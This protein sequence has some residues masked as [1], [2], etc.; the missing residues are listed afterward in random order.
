MKK[1]LIC[2]ATLILL[3][4]CDNGTKTLSCSQT[5]TS[6]GLSTDI[7]Y[8]IKYKD[9][10]VR[11]ATITYHYT[12]NDVTEENDTTSK[13]DVD[14]V[15]A[16]TDGL[17]ENRDSN[18]EN[19]NINSNDVVD[20]A[21]GDAVDTTINGVTDTILDI[22]GIRNTYE[23]QINTYKD[24]DGF[25]YKVEMDNEDEYKVVYEIDLDKI[26][27]SDL[28]RFNIDRDFSTFRTNYEN[29]GYVC[30]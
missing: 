29:S 12:R 24:I 9:N 15:K 16:D 18:D 30:R 28:T 17:T 27:D 11:Y 19:N 2:L 4:G 8:D 7:K 14:G 23:N 20:G 13:D 22:A 21:V 10:S 5:T 25:K 6:N 1:V 26:S 3:A